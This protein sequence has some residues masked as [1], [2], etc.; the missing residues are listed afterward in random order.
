MV[1]FIQA[2]LVVLIVE[3]TKSAFK[4]RSATSNN[5]SKQSNHSHHS[6]Q[7]HHGNHLGSQRGNDFDGSTISYADGLGASKAHREPGH[8]QQPWS[9]TMR[10]PAAVPESVPVHYSP[11]VTDRP[12]SS[13]YDFGN[14][15]QK[16][17]PNRHWEFD[18]ES[19]DTIDGSN[20]WKHNKAEDEIP[21]TLT[22][23]REDSE[24]GRR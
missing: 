18:A 22:K 8:Q 6:N 3:D 14:T 11:Q 7:V 20:R 12:L 15:D 4:K 24:Y 16:I 10:S 1:N 5:P 17:S 23:V 21:M 19:Q 9:L 2:I 13:F